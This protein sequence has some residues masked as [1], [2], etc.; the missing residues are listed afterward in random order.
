MRGTYTSHRHCLLMHIL[1]HTSPILSPLLSPTVP[2]TESG[3][4]SRR[5]IFAL[6]IE[7]K[8]DTKHTTHKNGTYTHTYTHNRRHYSSMS[9]KHTYSC[10]HSATII[11]GLV[12]WRMCMSK[13]CQCEVYVLLIHCAT[14]SHALGHPCLVS[15]F[16]CHPHIPH[17]LIRRIFYLLVAISFHTPSIPH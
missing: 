2:Y 17:F 1:H 16:L 10:A 4:E 13:Q 11:I 9:R 6:P 7:Y 5:F 15:C 12:W 14:T 3:F 8:Q